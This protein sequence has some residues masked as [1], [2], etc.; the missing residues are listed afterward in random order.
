MTITEPGPP[1]VSEH[2]EA[3]DPKRTCPKRAEISFRTPSLSKPPSSPPGSA[4]G[5]GTSPSNRVTWSSNLE[6]IHRLPAGQ[7]RRHLRVRPERRASGRPARRFVP[8]STRRYAPERPSRLLYRLPPRSERRRVLDR[9]AGDGGYGEWP[10][11]ADVRHLPGRHRS[12]K[13][14]P[15]IAP[16]RKPAGSRGAARR[17]CA[18]RERS[19]DFLR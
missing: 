17:A 18:D 6:N 12:R 15:G 3:A 14:A 9:V 10:R 2:A 11:G 8:Q 5:R 13:A 7:F 1:K 16:A 4:S 19:P